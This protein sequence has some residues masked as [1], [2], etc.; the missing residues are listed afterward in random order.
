MPLFYN[1]IH[2]SRNSHQ[3]VELNQEPPTKLP[4]T[5]IAKRKKNAIGQ[6]KN[7]S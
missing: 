3:Y 5:F 4:S 7:S 2:D 1:K 6:Y